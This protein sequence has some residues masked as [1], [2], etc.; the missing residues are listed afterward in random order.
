[1][2]QI[3]SILVVRKDTLLKSEIWKSSEKHQGFSTA[4]FLESD[5]DRAYT[6]KLILEKLKRNSDAFRQI[7]ERMS[8]V[9]DAL[10]KLAYLPLPPN[11]QPQ[12]P[13]AMPEGHLLTKVVNFEDVPIPTVELD[14]SSCG[15]G[16]GGQ[17]PVGSFPAI[18]KFRHGHK[19][20]FLRK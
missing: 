11:Q 20:M 14:V 13:V 17:Y 9:A 6:A 16:G 12:V 3:N 4:Y 18:A 15:G 7:V 1:M 2:A 5:D 10:I 8:L 19:I